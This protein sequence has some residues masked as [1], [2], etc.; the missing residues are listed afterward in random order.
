MDLEL[1]NSGDMNAMIDPFAMQTKGGMDRFCR[2][3]GGIL[4]LWIPRHPN[5]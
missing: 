2:S 3:L 5:P 1:S 4:E